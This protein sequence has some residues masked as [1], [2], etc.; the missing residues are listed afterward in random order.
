MIANF[1]IYILTK[2]FGQV[3]ALFPTTPSLPTAWTDT[4][5]TFSTAILNWESFFPV[6]DLLGVLGAILVIEGVLLG[7]RIAN[8]IFDKIRGSG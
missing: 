6:V 1:I 5:A 7:A 4:V 3:I 8:Y 2:I